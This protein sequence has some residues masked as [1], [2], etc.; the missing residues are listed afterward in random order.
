MLLRIRCHLSLYVYYVHIA[1]YYQLEEPLLSTA[2]DKMMV[3]AKAVTDPETANLETKFVEEAVVQNP[4]V[5]T[6]SQVF[7]HLWLLP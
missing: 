2:K 5:T 7:I 6:C 3:L 1:V 4:Q